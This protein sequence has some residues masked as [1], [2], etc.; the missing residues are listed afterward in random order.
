LC[1]LSSAWIFRC[2]RSVRGPKC[3][4]LATP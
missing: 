3:Q 1:S 4:L 2:F